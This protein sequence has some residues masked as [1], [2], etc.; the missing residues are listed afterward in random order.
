MLLFFSKPIFYKY[1]TSGLKY[2]C[3]DMLIYAYINN[4]LRPIALHQKHCLG[5]ITVI[6]LN[7]SIY[8][9]W[10]WFTLLRLF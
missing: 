7:K 5:V 4:N 10:L 2:K 8:L 3:A 1:Y 6:D 9:H